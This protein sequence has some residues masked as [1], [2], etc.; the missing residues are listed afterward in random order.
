M[1]KTFE[2][3]KFNEVLAS[4]YSIENYIIFE[5][6]NIH[7]RISLEHPFSF[8]GIAFITCLKGTARIKVNYKEYLITEDT[9][10]TMAPPQ[11]VEILEYS[12]DLL[13]SGLFFSQDSMLNLPLPQDF[14]ILENVLTNPVLRL[15]QKEIKSITTYYTFIVEIFNNNNHAY[16]KE[17]IK[18]LL[19]SLIYQVVAL[20]DQKGVNKNIPSGR[21]EEIAERFFL[22]LNDNYKTERLPSFYADKLCMSTKYLSSILKKVTGRSINSWLEE[23]IILG[24]KLL[25]K[26]TNFTVSQISEELNFPN[27]SYFGRYFKKVVGTTPKEYR[28]S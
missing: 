23:A 15:S 4:K 22:L 19:L 3:V 10:L 1:E 6:E 12:E 16:L 11:I 25:L 9:L 28:D 26:S 5:D 14:N 21:N 7:Q 2:R 18:G 20:Y 24:A 8:E 17:V 27:P 13:L